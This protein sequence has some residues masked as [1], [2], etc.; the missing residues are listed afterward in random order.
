MKKYKFV[1]TNT[2][3]RTYMWRPDGNKYPAV[4][5]TAC[6]PVMCIMVVYTFTRCFPL[7]ACFILLWLIL[8][9]AYSFVPRTLVIICKHFRFIAAALE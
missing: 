8:Y 1:N 6:G 9:A 2:H 7:S 3:R 4:L 5:V